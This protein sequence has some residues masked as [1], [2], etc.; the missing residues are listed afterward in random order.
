[1][2]IEAAG[3]ELD[4]FIS[5]GVEFARPL[6]RALRDTMWEHCGVVRSAEGLET[7]LDRIDELEGTLGDVDV[8]PSSEGYVDLTHVLDLRS[9]TV[10]ARATVL[11]ALERRETRGCHNRSDYEK[12]DDGFDVNIRCALTDDGELTLEHAP[13][14][15]VRE[16]LE[17][18][19][20][21]TEEPEVTGRLVE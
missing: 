5:P 14:P 9:A 18:W 13:V 2:V 10:T 19:A 1:L 6:Q 3:D 4:S 20:T 7:A 12:L 8:R 16:E 11:G 15:A 17:Q 21:V